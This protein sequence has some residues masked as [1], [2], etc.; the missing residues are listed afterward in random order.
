MK[1]SYVL[2]AIGLAEQKIKNSLR[3]SL[4]KFTTKGEIQKA[5]KKIKQLK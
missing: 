3:F 2:K 5:L 4:G 1:P